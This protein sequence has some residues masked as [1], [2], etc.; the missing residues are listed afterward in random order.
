M[1][2]ISGALFPQVF[3]KAFDLFTAFG[4]KIICS[5]ELLLTDVLVVQSTMKLGLNFATRTLGVTEKTD[6]LTSGPVVKSFGD[7]IH[8]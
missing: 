7:V 2:L 8:Y 5:A 1:P 6:A 3:P 4:G